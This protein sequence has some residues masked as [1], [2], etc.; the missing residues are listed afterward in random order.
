MTNSTELKT[1]KD[2]AAKLNEQL[3]IKPICD[4]KLIEK[5][6]IKMRAELKILTDS[7]T[8]TSSDDLDKMA[9]LMG[10]I[11]AYKDALLAH[12]YKHSLTEANKLIKEQD[13]E[14]DS[15]SYQIMDHQ[16]RP[17]FESG[18]IH[19]GHQAWAVANKRIAE[20]ECQKSNT[21]DHIMAIRP[22][23]GVLLLDD[24]LDKLINA[25]EAL[26]D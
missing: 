18:K 22:I 1:S 19:G 9:L 6:I 20:L 24:V 11:F 3:K 26:K 10:N 2:A 14:I 21:L 4:P 17:D 13:K 15:L 7:E 16:S 5:S 23:N 8:N 25:K 12:K